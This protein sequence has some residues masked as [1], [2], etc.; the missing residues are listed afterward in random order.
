MD[1]QSLILC[2]CVTVRMNRD[3]SVMAIH[4][5]KR[6]RMNNNRSIRQNMR[7]GK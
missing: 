1:T 6:M 4:F 5:V 2:R 3:G 7:M